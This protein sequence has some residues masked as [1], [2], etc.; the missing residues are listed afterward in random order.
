MSNLDP[1]IAEIDRRW[2]A[3][4]IPGL[5][6]GC[7]LPSGG[8]VSR[9]RAIN[10]RALLYPKPVLD[11]GQIEHL[12]LNGP[13]GPIPVRIVWPHEKFVSTKPTST[14]V[15]FHGGG[16]VVGDLDSHEAHAIRIAN[17]AQC[18]VLNVGYRLAP[19]FKFPIPVD[20]CWFATQWAYE[21]I[22][23]LGGN[24]GRFAVGGD[25]A[26]GNFA[27]V[28]ALLCRDSGIK[29]A[30]QLLMYPATDTT[31]IGEAEIRQAY[32]SNHAS[33]SLDPRASPL[34]AKTL[35][36]LA[37]TILGVGPYD[38]L[39]KDNLA[40][41]QALRAAN[42]PLMFREFPTLNHGFFSYTAVS[43][44]SEVAAIQLCHDLRAH[45]EQV[46]L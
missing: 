27:A 34:L 33:Q 26:G 22:D 36:G 43:K 32:F 12:E 37:P 46:N 19:E 13:H 23:R 29:L 15:Y 9:E 10:L 25:S 11:T 3:S 30:A 8:P 42:V 41:V 38:F 35:I 45:F 2:K 44:D 24:R 1:A 39:Y 4:G 21:H 20:D 28:M 6:D 14:V 40:Y 16:W 5:Y 17:E 7:N 31:K 18:V